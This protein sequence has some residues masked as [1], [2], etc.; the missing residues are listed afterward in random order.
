MAANIETKRRLLAIRRLAMAFPDRTAE[1]RLKTII[2]I[3][4][5]E[6]DTMTVRRHTS[7]DQAERLAA[8][9]A[10][11]SPKLAA[12]REGA[13]VAKSVEVAA[14]IEAEEEKKRK[15]RGGRDRMDESGANRGEE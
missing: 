11:R 4:K 7:P 13:K 2:G 8:G 6:I 15:K 1:E 5:G 9:M 12:R 10:S 14:A 3:A